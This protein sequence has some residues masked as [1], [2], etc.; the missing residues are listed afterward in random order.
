MTRKFTKY[1][2]TAD[3]ADAIEVATARGEYAYVDIRVRESG[4]TAEVNLSK[5]DAIAFAGDVLAAAGAAPALDVE[6]V[7]REI[8]YSAP[9]CSGGRDRR[10]REIAA[11]LRRHALPAAPRAV[12]EVQ[13]N[14]VAAAG[15][16][17][18]DSERAE[19]INARLRARATT[20]AAP[21]W[22]TAPAREVAG[23]LV[24]P[25]DGVYVREYTDGRHLPVHENGG[26]TMRTDVVRI[27]RIDTDAPTT[28]IERSAPTTVRE[29]TAE[30]C[31]QFVGKHLFM[32]RASGHNFYFPF[33]TEDAECIARRL[34]EKEVTAVHILP[35]ARADGGGR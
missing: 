31:E 34:N 18:T 6:A 26:D 2:C 5:P 16:C 27:R 28:W 24:V 4:E 32:H 22:I 17:L 23:G 30:V 35:A 19:F 25:E 12:V 8:S 29:W 21:Q 9:C 14:D 20:T 1:E 7:A 3:S 10:E 33:S 13:W 11:I 15:C